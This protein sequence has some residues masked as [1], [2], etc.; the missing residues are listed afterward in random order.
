MHEGYTIDR[1]TLT[2]RVFIWS[3]L[4]ESNRHWMY[5]Y[6][7]ASLSIKELRQRGDLRIIRRRHFTSPGCGN[8]HQAVYRYESAS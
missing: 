5:R 6:V 8:F 7:K 4:K 2:E 1:S 3:G